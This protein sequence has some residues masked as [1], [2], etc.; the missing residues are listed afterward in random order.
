MMNAISA[1][2]AVQAS[3]KGKP[4]CER[5]T[6]VPSSDFRAR[7]QAVLQFPLVLM[8]GVSPEPRKRGRYR[9]SID[10]LEQIADADLEILAQRLDRI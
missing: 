1:G 5:I 2:F 7:T 6:L 10:K 3:A 9:W 8:L 4:G